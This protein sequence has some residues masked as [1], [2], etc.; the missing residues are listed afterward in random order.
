MRLYSPISVSKAML[1]AEFVL[2]QI[3]QPG[4]SFSELRRPD[5][6]GSSVR[7]PRRVGHEHCEAVVACALAASA[8][9]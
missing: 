2:F 9:V 5:R 4:R 1:V 6:R 7:F 8:G 3:D